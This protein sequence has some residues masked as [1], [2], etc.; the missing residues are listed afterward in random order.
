MQ[1]ENSRK[2]LTSNTWIV[3]KSQL[4]GAVQVP[5]S[6]S[7]T[8]RA[9]LFASLASGISAILNPLHSPDVDAMLRACS[10]LGAKFSSCQGGICVRGVQ[11]QPQTPYRPID[12]GNSGQ[13]LRFVGAISALSTGLTQLTGD[14]SIRL[15]RPIQPLI[16]GLQGLGV[17]VEA[18]A[19]PLSI[20]GPVK[21][22]LTTLDGTDSQPVSALLMLAS[23][24]EGETT[25]Q[26]RNPGETPW[27]ELT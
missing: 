10:Q 25:L 17:F 20:K 26:V 13:V 15:L 9:L 18:N 6:K 5:P 2:N 21:T 24:L 7:H 11:G 16:E 1:S 4:S 22:R 14:A 27:I 8:M 12:C 19:T 3:E 23:F